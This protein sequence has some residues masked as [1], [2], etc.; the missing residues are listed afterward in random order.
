MAAKRSVKKEKTLI[1]YN[2]IANFS[3]GFNFEETED[4]LA[5][6]KRYIETYLQENQ[7][8]D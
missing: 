1:D 8:I 5:T 7:W 4:Q 3:K 2:T 6:L